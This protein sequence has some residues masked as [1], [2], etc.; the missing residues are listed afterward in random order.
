MYG[1]LLFFFFFNIRDLLIHQDLSILTFH[2]VIC[3]ISGNLWKKK[4]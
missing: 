4:P 1:S 3:L 2:S